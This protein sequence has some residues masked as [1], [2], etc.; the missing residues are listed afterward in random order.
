MKEQA[1]VLISISVYAFALIFYNK[2]NKMLYPLSKD[3]P[4]PDMVKGALYLKDYEKH[5]K[6]YK[7]YYISLYVAGFLTVMVFHNP[8]MA[9]VLAS[10]LVASEDDIKSLMVYDYYSFIPALAIIIGI[11]IIR[12][13]FE[14]WNLVP[15]VF[16]ILSIYTR[17]RA[18]TFMMII[19]GLYGIYIND[20]FAVLLGYT[21]AYIWQLLFQL[22][23]CGKHHIRYKERRKMD[24]F[25]L[26]FMPALS[27]G[28]MLGFYIEYIMM[29]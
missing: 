24:G 10:C 20:P 9:L 29:G 7:I 23:M 21:M 11:I 5:K 19:F 14:I 18:D 12:P 3:Q 17:G 26:P 16:C 2:L 1:E 22:V 15:V 13:H 8:L 28:F 25:R 6:L 4:V 27:I